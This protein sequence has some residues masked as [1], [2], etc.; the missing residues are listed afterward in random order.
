MVRREYRALAKLH[1]IPG[2]PTEPF[3][4]DDYALC[5]RYIPGAM[6]RNLPAE[7]FRDDFFLGLERLVAAIHGRN[8]VHLDLRNQRNILM[9]DDGNPALIDFQSSIHLER[10]PGFLRKLL[11]NID[12]SGVYKIWSKKSPETLDSTRKSLLEAVNRKRSLWF[13]RGYPLGTR[14]NRRL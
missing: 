10:V 1:G 3:L 11:K 7:R 8:L 4:L 14:K 12:I 6:V 5:Y 2:V 13:F 9:G